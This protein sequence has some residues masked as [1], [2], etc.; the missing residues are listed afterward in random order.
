MV[1]G[2]RQLSM[3]NMYIVTYIRSPRSRPWEDRQLRSREVTMSAVNGL[4]CAQ[5]RTSDDDHRVVRDGGPALSIVEH[6]S[7]PV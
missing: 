3:I 1:R 6:C 4:I 7:K 5:A 2:S